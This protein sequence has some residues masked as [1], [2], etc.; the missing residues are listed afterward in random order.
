MIPGKIVRFLEPHANLAFAGTRS[1]DR[2]PFG[3]RVSASYI[4]ADGHS[5][6][7]LVAEQFTARLVESLPELPIPRKLEAILMTCLEKDPAKRFASALELDAQLAL[8]PGTD[9][10][11]NRRAEAWWNANAPDTVARD[12]SS[13]W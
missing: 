8:V 12:T 3:H 6:T 2:A 5:L 9:P 1:R 10:W 7:A 11:T 13:E 4:G